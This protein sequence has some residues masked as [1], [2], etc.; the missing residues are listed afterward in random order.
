MKPLRNHQQVWPLPGATRISGSRKI[1]TRTRAPRGNRFPG[2]IER[3]ALAPSPG[4]RTSRRLREHPGHW[5]LRANEQ[6]FLEPGGGEKAEHHGR[7]LSAVAGAL[8][9]WHQRV[10]PP[11]EARPLLSPAELWLGPGSSGRQRR[12]VSH[13]DGARPGK[14]P[15]A[16]RDA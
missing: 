5:P 13:G 4:R 14:R 15:S 8:W 16:P 6:R 11:P 12:R 9:V 3:S 2:A 7:P 1:F 10:A